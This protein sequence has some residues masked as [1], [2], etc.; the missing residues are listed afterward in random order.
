MQTLL[1]NPLAEP[2]VL[3]ISGGAAVG[4]LGAILFGLGSFWVTS[5][6]FIGALLSML[7]LFALAHGRGGWTTARLLLTGIV[8]A[9]GWG[10]LITFMLAVS[11][12][13][14]LRSMM[15]WLM[16]DLSGAEK[17][18]PGLIALAIGLALCLPPARSLTLLGHGEYQARSLGIEVKR[19]RWFIYFVTAMLTAVAVTL[20]GT[21]GFVGLV[22]PHLMR[23]VVGNDQR[24]L[25][26]A[27]TLFGG[28]LLV[29]ADTLARTIIA[30]QQLPVGVIT[31]LIGVPLFLYL[32]HRSQ[33]V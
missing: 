26:P 18:L 7:L 13:D 4:A 2:Y 30:P 8:I 27:A 1:R 21:I 19:L 10:A 14:Q 3:G 31:A 17:P 24:V 15:F 11:D 6:S 5:G 12:N 33:R 23:L 20:A 9:A 32:L 28:A 29:C 22:V 16:G 25:L